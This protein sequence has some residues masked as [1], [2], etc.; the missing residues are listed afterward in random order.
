M[1]LRFVENQRSFGDPRTHELDELL[2]ALAQ[3][4]R[5]LISGKDW[6]QGPVEVS[7]VPQLFVWKKQ[8][9]IIFG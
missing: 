3:E 9:D 4:K 5:R 2:G 7:Q 6:F 1:G 8:A